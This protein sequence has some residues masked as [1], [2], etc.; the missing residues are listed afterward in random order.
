MSKQELISATIPAVVSPAEAAGIRDEM[1]AKLQGA[2]DGG[3]KLTIE[4]DG[5]QPNPCSLQILIGAK[6][7]A[8][9]GDLKIEWAGTGA[10]AFSE[11]EVN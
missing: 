8:D 4:I 3:R 7:S 11:I 2:K 5:E 1:L 9:L 10:D 6:R